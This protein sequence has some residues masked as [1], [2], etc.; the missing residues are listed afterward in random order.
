MGTLVLFTS[1]NTLPKL[2]MDADCDWLGTL[3][4]SISA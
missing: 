3:S 4:A 1:G 2:G